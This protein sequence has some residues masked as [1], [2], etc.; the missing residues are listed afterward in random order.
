M[1]NP[2]QS[3]TLSLYL[4]VLKLCELPYLRIPGSKEKTITILEEDHAKK[5][6]A[7]LI[8]MSQ[9]VKSL[10]HFTS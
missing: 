7:M 2:I 6:R 4:K 5:L 1:G 8:I 3:L 10:N 9:N